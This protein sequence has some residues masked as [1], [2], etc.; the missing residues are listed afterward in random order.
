MLPSWN[1]FPHALFQVLS[2]HLGRSN[3]LYNWNQKIFLSTKKCLKLSSEK[4][5]WTQDHKIALKLICRV[6][7]KPPT[8]LVLS[9][10]HTISRMK[11]LNFRSLCNVPEALVEFVVHGRFF[12]WPRLRPWPRLLR[13]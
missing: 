11:I 9:F 5:V 13:P 2:V 3:V 10:Y 8:G 4:G 7:R 1:D 12:H 6:F